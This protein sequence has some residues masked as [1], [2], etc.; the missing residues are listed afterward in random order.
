MSLKTEARLYVGFFIGA[1]TTK[2]S[3]NVVVDVILV[4]ILM[5][6]AHYV[7]KD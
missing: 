3:G 2:L 1:L 4:T 5:I 7:L 6:I